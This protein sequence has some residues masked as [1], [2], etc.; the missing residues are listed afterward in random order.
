MK[1]KRKR[2][3][4]GKVATKRFLEETVGPYQIAK[5]RGRLITGSP[6]ES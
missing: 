1:F 4:K 3:T 6:E 5:L 2:H